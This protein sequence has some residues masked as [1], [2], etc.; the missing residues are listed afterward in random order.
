MVTE[1]KNS[2]PDGETTVPGSQLENNTLGVF[3]LLAQ[4]TEGT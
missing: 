2:S 3:F 4:I 1:Q